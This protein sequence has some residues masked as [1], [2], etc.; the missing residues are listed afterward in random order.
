MRQLL[1]I[2]FALLFSFHLSAQNWQPIDTSRKTTHFLG[3][4]P[5]SVNSFGVYS[6]LYPIQSTVIDSV[7]IQAGNSVVLF[8]RGFSLTNYNNLLKGRILG[9][10]MILKS[11]YTEFKTID[12]NGFDLFFPTSLKANQSWILGRS[13]TKE[14][15]ATVDSIRWDSISNFAYDSIATISIEAYN[16]SNQAATSHPFNGTIKI[17]KNNGLVTTID[18]MEMQYQRTYGLYKW[19]EDTITANDFYNLSLGDEVA[20]STSTSSFYSAASTHIIELIGDSTSGQLRTLSFKD[21]SVSSFRDLNSPNPI[22]TTYPLAIDTTTIQLRTD[23]IFAFAYSGIVEDTISSH[24]R[25]TSMNFPQFFVNKAISDSIVVSYLSNTLKAN[26]SHTYFDSYNYINNHFRDIRYL[27]IGSEYLRQLTRSSET[28]TLEY[29]NL[30]GVTYGNKP[31][32]VSL[33]ES[34]LLGSKRTI[35]VYPNPT[36]EELNIGIDSKDIQLI[37]IF[38]TSGQIVLS[39]PPSNRIDI[40]SLSPGIYFI[41]IANNKETFTKKIIKE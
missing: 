9:D 33:P 12:T 35:N 3:D 22:D 24:T 31:I 15:R 20:Y 27:G 19:E 8:K 14:L 23:S 10:T 34:N 37:T 4:F 2:C 17:S 25:L 39:P 13:P 7:Y 30:G 38:N 36:K 28:K 6:Q 29:V 32:L 1:F 5:L 11:N 18:F 40:S 21:E 26:S 41:R 16:L